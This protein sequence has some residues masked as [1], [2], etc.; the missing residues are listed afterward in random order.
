MNFVLHHLPV[1]LI[2]IPLMAAPVCLLVR[3]QT[4]AW[5]FA[6]CITTI[7]LILSVMLFMMVSDN[8]FYSYAVGNWPSPWGIELAVDYLNA[9]VLLIVTSAGFLCCLYAKNSVKKEIASE[10]TPLFYTA[11]LLNFAGLIGVL[12]TGDA[13]NLF[14]FIEIASISSYALVS[15]GND[16][17]ALYGAYRYL[18]MGTIGATFILIGLGF[19]YVMTGTLN[20]QDLAERIP[21]VSQSSTV[22]TGICFIFLGSCIKL[23]LFPMHVWLPMVYTYSPSVISIYFAATTTKVFIYVLIRYIYMIFGA[24][25]I[26]DLIL[27]KLILILSS[28]AI[29]YG[30]IKAITATNIKSIF[31]YSSISQIGYMVLGLGLMTV[32]GLSAT[33]L[34]LFNHAMIKAAIFMSLGCIIY[35]MGSEKLSDMKGML[36]TMPMTS[37][38]FILACLSLIGI[39]ATSGFLSKWYLVLAVIE[40]QAWVLVVVIMIGSL[41]SIIYVWRVIEV[42]Y[43]QQPENIH[44]NKE[45]TAIPFLMVLPLW[46]L[47]IANIYYG[48]DASMSYGSAN[49]IAKYLI[50]K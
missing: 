46:L 29:L 18:V 11:Y 13:F 6:F 21:G 15:M 42:M 12:L 7:C 16:K 22:I 14:V 35:R 36:K 28:A 20:I 30:A 32:S 40:Q 27:P 1:L 48:L 23:A 50:L 43:F 8:V 4:L 39:P 34:H 31:A 24:D 47:I 45:L 17:R 44:A 38:A 25:I 2:I 37:V 3:H 5:L 33:I 49:T 9:F 26:F 19:L 41:L 10:K